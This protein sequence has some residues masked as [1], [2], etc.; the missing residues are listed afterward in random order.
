MNLQ[1]ALL[2]A[3]VIAGPFALALALAILNSYRSAIRRAMRGASAD[4]SPSRPDITPRRAPAARLACATERLSR[5]RR[6]A[7]SS[8]PSLPAAAVHVAGGVTF[9]LVATI[10]VFGFSGIEFLPIRFA[11]VVL[12]YAWPTVLALNILWT[13]DRTRQ[14][15]VVAV[16][17]AGLIAL[18]LWMGLTTKSRPVVVSGVTLPVFLNPAAFWALTAAPS[19]Y[20]LVFASRRVRAVGPV[21]LTFV[22]F[23]TAGAVLAPSLIGTSLGWR[24]T[25]WA[26]TVIGLSAFGV[27]ALVTLAGAAVGAVLGWFGVQTLAR[28]YESRRESAHGLVTD[29]IWLIQSLMVCSSIAREAGCWGVA[30]LVPFAT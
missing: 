29:T 23:L 1:G 26:M 25:I 15:A 10:L 13:G 30:G 20:L 9:G 4:A 17:A 6:G 22:A 8:D 7:H 14:A 24:A 18:C 12:G 21:V 27:F 19:V 5:D 2:M 16:Y 11:A 3:F 28:A